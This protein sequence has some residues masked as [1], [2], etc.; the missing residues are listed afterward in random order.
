VDVMPY[1]A[2]DTEGMMEFYAPAANDPDSGNGHVVELGPGARGGATIRV[3]VRR[4][5]AI[6]AASGI[7]RLDLSS[8]T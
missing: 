7:G 6:I 2:A 4:L 8:S 5:D 3:E 1:A